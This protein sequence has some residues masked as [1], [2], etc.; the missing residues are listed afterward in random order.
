MVR[1]K[2]VQRR[3]EAVKIYKPVGPSGICS[4]ENTKPVFVPDSLDDLCGPTAGRVTLPLHIDWTPSNT[5]DLSDAVNTCTMYATVLREAKA[6]DDLSRFLDRE[7]LVRAWSSL[8]LPDFIRESW[9]R[10]FPQL[11]DT[12]HG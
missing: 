3:S 1:G 2:S 11:L 9:E 4:F 5:Y 12:P 8:R 6:E 10:R 7:L